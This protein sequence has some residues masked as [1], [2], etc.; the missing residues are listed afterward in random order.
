[1]TATQNRGVVDFDAVAGSQASLPVNSTTLT[2]EKREWDVPA[3][4]SYGAG[5]TLTPLRAG[6]TLGWRVAA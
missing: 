3:H 4:Y 6:E 2:L 5:A 1:M